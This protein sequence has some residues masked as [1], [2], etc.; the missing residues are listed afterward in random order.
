MQAATAQRSWKSTIP[1]CDS[2]VRTSYECSLSLLRSSA[3]HE[4][5]PNLGHLANWVYAPIGDLTR[6]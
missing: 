4:H 1:P 6:P 2:V 5:G 3:S